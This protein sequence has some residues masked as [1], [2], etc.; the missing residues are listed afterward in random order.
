MFLDRGLMRKDR[1]LED[2]NGC[3]ENLR[4]KYRPRNYFLDLEL[5]ILSLQFLI[6]L[7]T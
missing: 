6:Y 7:P 5:M 4:E 3:L 1:N 2:P